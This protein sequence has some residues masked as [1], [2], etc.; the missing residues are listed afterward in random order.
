MSFDMRFIDESHNGGTTMLAK[1]TLEFYGKLS[2]TIQITATYSKPINDYNIPKDCWILWDLEDIK[3]CKNIKNDDSIIR[4]VEKHG[5]CIKDI[6]SKY[7]QDSIISEYSKYPEL[8]LLTDEI[9]PDV[10]TEI[11]NDTQDNNYGWSPDACFLL[12]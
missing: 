6:I 11:I 1:K 3:L 8:W 12:K 2:F 10:V 9:D 5:D 7:S 4:L